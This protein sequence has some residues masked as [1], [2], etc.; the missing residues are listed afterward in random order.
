MS[1]ITRERR[2][3]P[4]RRAAAGE[5]EAVILARE[6]AAAAIRALASIADDP[7]APATARVAAA[8]KLLERGYGRP[9]GENGSRDL[10]GLTEE[11][12]QELLRDAD[13]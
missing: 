3:T 2:Q 8:A 12:L 7:D 9:G 11:Q 5:D 1:K 13:G 6:Y 10:S 4:R